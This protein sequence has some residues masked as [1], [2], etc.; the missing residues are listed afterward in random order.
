MAGSS[1]AGELEN[2]CNQLIKEVRKSEQQIVFFVDELHKIVGGGGSGSQD[3]ANIF[4]PALASGEIRM[5]G[6]T[7]IREYRQYIEKDGAL[8]RRFQPILVDEPTKEETLEILL[9]LR[10]HYAKYHG[11]VFSVTTAE[12][13]V[14]LAERY[15]TERF[16]PDKSIDLMDEASSMVSMNSTAKKPKV[17]PIDIAI[18][19]SR[20]K[21]IPLE[22]L[23]RTDEQ[24][25]KNIE[26]EIGTK[27]VGQRE[28]IN[29][30]ASAIRRSFAGL[31][32]RRKPI[33]SFLFLGPTGVGKTELARTLAWW[34]FD[35]PDAIVKLDMSEFQEAHSVARLFG[36]PPGYVGHEQ[37]GQLT[38]PVIRRP[39]SV[40]LLDEIEKANPV[41]WNTLLQVMDDGRMTD[42]MG[43]QANFSNTILIMTS[44][45][46]PD[47]WRIESPTRK[48]L[49]SRLMEE[50]FRPEFLNRFDGL[51]VFQHLTVDNIRDIAE[52]QLNELKEVV[53]DKGYT[54]EW[55]DGVT[56]HLAKISHNNRMDARPLRRNISSHI[57]DQRALEY[58]N[59][60]I[61]N[62]SI[63]KFELMEDKIILEVQ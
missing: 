27:I 17:R 52:L 57:G 28:S 34:M 3:I 1:M 49:E 37:G 59:G 12:E 35:D 18:V 26:E 47:L 54:I 15:V 38:E 16:N 9:K 2:R 63:V 56:E 19:V 39:Y 29:Q 41:V 48:K 24:R 58:A 30:V 40:V 22:K 33:G 31:D 44:N 46:C 7:T 50:G 4:K 21:G 5:M 55:S 62:D 32:I 51:S 43:R 6:A 23:T 60:N 13:A 10:T 53:A 36:A 45:A 20:K 14:K 8:E 11:V 42:G 61:K 25:V